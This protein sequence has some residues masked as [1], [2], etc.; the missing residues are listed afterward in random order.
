MKKY[1]AVLLVAIVAVS[2]LSAAGV[3]AAANSKNIPPEKPPANGLPSWGSTVAVKLVVSPLPVAVTVPQTDQLIRVT[4][5]YDKNFD[6]LY[7]EPFTHTTETYKCGRVGTEASPIKEYASDVNHDGHQDLTLVFR[8]KD[9]GL[10]PGDLQGKLTGT[11][12]QPGCCNAVPYHCDMVCP[13]DETFT[14]TGT[15]FVLVV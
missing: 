5:L 2:V 15:A 10:K 7:Y 1:F 8:A 4:I 12:A 14:V 6:P 9:T 3:V 13:R 11:I